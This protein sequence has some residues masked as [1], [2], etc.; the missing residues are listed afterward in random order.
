MKKFVVLALAIFVLL[1]V[2]A[3]AQEKDPACAPGATCIEAP[4]TVT[5]KGPDA[6]KVKGPVEVKG[7]V[8]VK[9]KVT[10]DGVDGTVTVTTEDGASLPVEVTEPVTVTA[11][12]PLPIA[13]PEGPIEVELPLYKEWWF[14]TAV[15][16]VTTGFI[17]G[18]VCAGGYCGGTHTNNV[19]FR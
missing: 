4:V 10:V 2:V 15:G 1:P 19:E 14:W 6:V 9:G 16:I 11:E 13:L 5:V 7:P 18:G 8:Q 17:V 12:D 3:L